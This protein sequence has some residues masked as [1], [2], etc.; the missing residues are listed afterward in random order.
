MLDCF[1]IG[2]ENIVS[3][4]CWVVLVMYR[5]IFWFLLMVVLGL[6]LCIVWMFRCGLL[7]GVLVNSSWFCLMVRFWL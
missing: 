3:I 2:C 5:L 4:G 1:I 7:I 6:S